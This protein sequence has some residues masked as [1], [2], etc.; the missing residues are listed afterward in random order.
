MICTQD[1]YLLCLLMYLM[2]ILKY[3]E[4][5]NL[6]PLRSLDLKVWCY[7]V[8]SAFELLFDVCYA[9]SA[10]CS[11]FVPVYKLCKCYS[12]RATFPSLNEWHKL[13]AI[14]RWSWLL[15]LKDCLELI[16]GVECANSSTAPLPS[17]LPKTLSETD[18]WRWM[19]LEFQEGNPVKAARTDVRVCL[20]IKTF[21][22]LR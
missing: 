9:C 19:G 22:A 1:D 20:D 3:F 15:V 8:S 13:V 14:R 18:S 16:L 17:Q 21:S 11:I 2:R 6:F 5:L 12:I 10:D 4:L 7:F